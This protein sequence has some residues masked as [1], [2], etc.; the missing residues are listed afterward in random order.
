MRVLVGILT[1]VL[2]LFA[3]FVGRSCLREYQQSQRLVPTE[4]VIVASRLEVSSSSAADPHSVSSTYRP[5]ISYFYKIGET[6]FRG[7]RYRISLPG[8]S[9]ESAS[10]ILRDYAV[11]SRVTIWY[12][13][14]DPSFAVPPLVKI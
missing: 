8:Y 9:Y 12:D 13:P 4:G 10:E 6:S 11:G 14:D 2:F 3:V 1:A 7:E 5:V